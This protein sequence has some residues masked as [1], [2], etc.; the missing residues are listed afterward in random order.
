MKTGTWLM[1]LAMLGVGCGSGDTV[2]QET[3]RDAA[4]GGAGGTSVDN[5]GT[6]GHG[7]GG[8]SSGTGAGG[9]GAGGTGASV[10]GSGG[11]GGH[12]SD[13]GRAVDGGA[14]DAVPVDG[15]STSDATTGRGDTT[16]AMDGLP[17]GQ[18]RS[19]SDC[20]PTV[21][22]AG[23]PYTVWSCVASDETPP[24]SY[25]SPIPPGM[26]QSSFCPDWCGSSSCPVLPTSPSGT[27]T[28]CTTSGD[29][30]Q[31]GSTGVAVASVCAN[32]KCTQC[33]ADAD[34][35]ST[36]PACAV[37]GVS[38]FRMCSECAKDSQC[39][40]AHPYCIVPTYLGGRCSDCR[41][42]ADCPDGVC[43]SNYTCVPGCAR[44]IDCGNP[45]FRCSSHRCEQV[46]C[47][48]TK[49]CPT[50]ATCQSG[51]CQRSACAIDADCQSNACVK[52]RCYGA[53]GS[54]TGE[55]IG[56]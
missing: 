38:S 5:S 55:T 25:V 8:Q 44:D 32:G 37:I 26:C 24:P 35:P 36:V 54:C 1:A 52:G 45:A 15:V 18:C 48:G 43:G 23:N 47:T 2:Q 28:A 10:I 20:P 3:A 9:T 11:S 7:T 6:G 39:P 17:P 13:S 42:T 19:A 21:P 41:T 22:V 51:M 40:S 4:V 29:C 27:G 46:P 53:Y 14:I 56:V 16:P 12:S 33:A 49:D 31:P 34:C 50:D 30:P